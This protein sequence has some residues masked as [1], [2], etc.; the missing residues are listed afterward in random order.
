MI[1]PGTEPVI[2]FGQQP[3]GF[4]PRRF[5]WAKI[6]TARR[7]QEQIGG[8]IVFFYHDSDHDPRE[9]QT[10]LRERREGSEHS[11]NFAFT[12][13][14]QKK[15]TP[16]YA[17]RIRNG[18]QQD[19]IRQ[20]PKYL[21]RKYLSVFDSLDTRNVADFCLEAYRGLGLLDGIDV[22]RSSDPQV[23][24]A[25][26]EIEDFFVDTQYCGETVRAR[27]DPRHGLR[28]HQ[29]GDAYIDLADKTWDKVRISPSRDTRLRWMQSVVHCS[30]YIAGAGEMC[31]LRVEETPEI[32]FVE[33]DAIDDPEKAYQP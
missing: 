18:W 10:I 4:L 3:C 24:Q 5:L 1:S 21:D 6:C 26:C 13:K 7:L 9:T 30:H 22:L 31:Y 33:R 15:F 23:R 27:F 8:R 2:C 11:I 29:G 16:L 12:N 28:L 14:L 19:L 17:K 25:A 32:T 20:L